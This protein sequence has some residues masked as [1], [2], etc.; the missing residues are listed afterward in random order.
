MEDISGHDA[1]AAMV[2]HGGT[3][4]WR[5]SRAMGHAGQYLD[6]AVRQGRVLSLDTAARLADVCFTD[7]ALVDRETGEAYARIRPPAREGGA[8]DGMTRGDGEGAGA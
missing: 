4:L 6:Q 5:A 2:G 3:T 1:V 8:R 7:I